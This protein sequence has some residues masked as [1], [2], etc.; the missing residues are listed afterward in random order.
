M[1]LVGAQV[2]RSSQLIST[3]TAAVMRRCSG[4]APASGT[5]CLR[6]AAPKACRGAVHRTSWPQR[7]TMATARRT[8]PSIDRG[9]GSGFRSDPVGITRI[10]P[11]SGG[12]PLATFPCPPTT[13]AM[14]STTSR[15]TGHQPGIVCRHSS[16]ATGPTGAARQVTAPTFLCRA[17]T[18]RTARPS[19]RRVFR[20]STCSCYLRFT[21]NGA[22]VVV[23]WGH[24]RT[25]RSPGY[26]WRR[27]HVSDCRRS[28]GRAA[29]EHWPGRVSCSAPAATSRFPL[30]RTVDG[31]TTRCVRPSTGTGTLV[32][33]S[34]GTDA[35][36]WGN[37][38]D[39]PVH[40]RFDATAADDRSVAVRR[41]RARAHAER[42][43]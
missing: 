11:L 9:P 37:G 29:S 2:A 24:K 12:A 17:I 35:A 28:K 39:R 20:P 43:L 3:A 7:T 33:R 40:G 31:L 18:T 25:F 34:G 19:S 36:Q 4:R 1:R 30:I 26:R 13:M 41:S 23:T 15:C 14:E 27:S 8:S 22:P 38:L 32:R 42:R 10:G 16:R 6:T 5:R 21:S